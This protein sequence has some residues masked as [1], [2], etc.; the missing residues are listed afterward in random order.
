MIFF[1][2]KAGL[3]E[4]TGKEEEKKTNGVGEDNFCAVTDLCAVQNGTLI[5]VAIQR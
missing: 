3:L 1:F 4:S 2:L 5:A